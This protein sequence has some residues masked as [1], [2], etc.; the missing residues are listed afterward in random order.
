[1][2]LS[3]RENQYLIKTYCYLKQEMLPQNSDNMQNYPPAEMWR[4]VRN[5]IEKAMIAIEREL[6]KRKI[7]I[8]SYN[9]ESIK[10]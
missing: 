2:D 5:E 8:S 4:G 7:D 9:C 6:Q 10:F 1:M 3:D